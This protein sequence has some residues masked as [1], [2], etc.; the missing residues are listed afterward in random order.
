[1]ARAGGRRRGERRVKGMQ[2]NRMKGLKR[3]RGREDVR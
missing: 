2:A 3:R 1:M